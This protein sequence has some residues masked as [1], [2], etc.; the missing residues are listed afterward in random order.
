M[1]A[2]NGVTLLV[3]GL[4]ALTRQQWQEFIPHTPKLPGLSALLNRGRKTVKKPSGFESLLGAKFAQNLQTP[5]PVATLTYLYDKNRLPQEYVLR[6]DPVCLKADR[7]CLFLLGHKGLQITP[8]EAEKM[9]AEIN[10]IYANDGWSVEIGASDR[11]YIRSLEKPLV[12]TVPLSEVFGKNVAPYLPRG[13]EEK[14]W[15]VVLT[16]LQMLLHNN[17]VNVQRAMHH[18]PVINSVW[19]WGEGQLPEFEPHPF[20]KYERV[21]SNEALCCGLAHWAHCKYDKLPLTANEW[22]EQSVAGRQLIVFDDMRVLQKESFHSWVD[23]LIRLDEQWFTPLV[24]AM[25]NKLL[26]HLQVEFENGLLFEIAKRSNWNKW[27]RKQ[28]LWFEWAL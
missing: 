24:S 4:F 15:R 26:T 18:Q 11:W 3:P 22:V 14:K 10:A 20:G 13:P 12:D 25:D 7:D 19:I 5:L 17:V 27:W 2:A 23:Q 16:E 1:E 28:R 9:V 6:A 21:W 8:D